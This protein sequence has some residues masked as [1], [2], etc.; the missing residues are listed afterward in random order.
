MG[1][2]KTQSIVCTV[3]FNL[4]IQAVLQNQACRKHPKPCKK[5]MVQITRMFL[6]YLLYALAFPWPQSIKQIARSIYEAK[7]P[8][9]FSLFALDPIAYMDFPMV[10]I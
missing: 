6:Q 2:G 5:H 4:A 9:T 8:R 7:L 1:H 10:F 3:D